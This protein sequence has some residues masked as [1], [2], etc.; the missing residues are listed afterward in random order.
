M[1]PGNPR[2]QFRLDKKRGQRHHPSRFLAASIRVG[3]VGLP[4]QSDAS[5]WAGPGYGNG[6]EDR[7]LASIK[8]IAC[9]LPWRVH[10]LAHPQVAA[11]LRRSASCPAPRCLWAVPN[12]THP[13]R[14]FL[15]L[16]W[17]TFHFLLRYNSWHRF[18]RSALN[19]KC[20]HW[21]AR[22]ALPVGPSH[23]S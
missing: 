1:R 17:C 22:L 18:F 19:L 8:A 10:V 20:R 13:S 9:S 11:N 14:R 2:L 3:P 15:R 4:E 6:I 5:L 16:L 21:R 23:L 7:Q 12:Y